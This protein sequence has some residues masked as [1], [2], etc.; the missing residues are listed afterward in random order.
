MASHRGSTSQFERLL[1][2]LTRF[3]AVL[4]ALGA[5]AGI[6]LTILFF[7]GKVGTTNEVSYRDVQIK[8]AADRP[9]AETSGE[10]ANISVPQPNYALPPN[11]QKYM[12]YGDNRQVLDGWLAELAGAQ[13]RS[14]FLQNM[15][16]IIDDAEKNHENAV[17][18][19]NAYK[20]I[21]LFRLTGVDQYVAQGKRIGSVMVALLFL[22]ILVIAS[23]LL[24]MLA[25][26]RHARYRTR[27][28]VVQA[29]RSGDAGA[30][31]SLSPI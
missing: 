28:V 31:A 17:Y 10:T 2:G 16:A 27:E 29:A 9:D 26:E 5:L 24:V 12:G 25:I 8:L 20:D 21:K 13:E 1:F 6:V 4:I 15:S 18:A 22:L 7:F 19:V 11:V 23:Q 3:V 30:D 14:D